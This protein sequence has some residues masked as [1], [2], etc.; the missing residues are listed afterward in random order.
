MT[1][2]ALIRGLLLP[3][4]RTAL[5]LAAVLTFV[6]A[7]NNFAVPAILQVKV[8]PAEMWVRFNTTF[9]TLGTLKLSWP[10]VAGPLLLLLCFA[11]RQ[12]PWPHLSAPVPPKLFRQQLGLGWFWLCGGVTL[13]V[14]FLAVGLPLFQ[15]LS[16]KRT[17]TELPGALA[18]GQA[19]SGT[20]SAS[21]PLPPP[22]SSCLPCS[23]A[24]EPFPATP[25]LP[26]V[27]YLT[28]LTHL[29]LRLAGSPSS[30]PASC[31]A[32]LSSTSSTARGLRSSIKAR[33]SSSWLSC[34]LSGVGLGVRRRTP[35]AR[36]TRT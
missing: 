13:L 8:F 32:S 26:H 19:P 3:L 6:L 34:P 35:S 28:C 15:L 25:V 21:L 17:W 5:A 31:S 1:G 33:G 4:A 36:W 20:P 14:C 23:S 7:L 10:L 24:Y 2:W 16:I 9:D 22:S 11:R 12:I 27:T 18:A 29:P 30:S